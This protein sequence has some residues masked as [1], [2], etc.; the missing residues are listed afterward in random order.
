MTGF[1]TFV[2]VDYSARSVPSPAKPSPDSIWIAVARGAKIDVT[3]HRT[4]SAAQCAL[5]D[6]FESEIRKDRRVLTGFDFPF[7]YPKGFAQAMTGSHDPFALWKVLSERIEDHDDNANNRFD[8][9]EEINQ[10]F[11]APGPFWGCPSGRSTSDLEGTKPRSPAF[12]DRREI[13]EH[14]LRAQTCWKLF[15]TGSVGSQALLGIPRLYALREHFGSDLAVAPFETSDAA[16]VLT[17]IYPSLLAEEVEAQ[18]L[19][20]EILDATQV[21]VVATALSNLAPDRLNAMLAEG[22]K[23]EGWIFG[24]GHVGELIRAAQSKPPLAPPRLQDNCFALPPGVDWTPVPEALARLKA[25]LRPVTVPE[26]LNISQ[27]AG[28]VIALDVHAKRSNPPTANSAVDGFG[29][30]HSS[31]T[32]GPQTLP[33]VEGRSAAG[34]P[35]AG[36]VPAGHAIRIL[37][38]AAIPVGVDTVVLEEDCAVAPD[39]LAFHG[40]VKPGANTRKAGEDV[41]ADDV[42]FPVG[43]RLRAPDLALLAATGI[44]E[45]DVFRPLR[46]AVLSTGDELLEAGAK[47]AA[48]QIYDANRPMLAAMLAGWGYDVVDLGRQPDDPEIIRSVLDRAA[49]DVD[50][51]L[52]SGGASAGDEDHISRLL[53]D[54]GSLS[55]WRIA[56]KPGRPL[57]LA[58]WH[59]VPVFG[60]PGNPVAAL[61]CA[62]LFARP[63][64]SLLAGAGWKEPLR[65]T[66]PAGFT[67]SKKHGRAEYPRAR[68]TDDGKV[69]L[70]KSEGSGRISG[71]TWAEGLVELPFEARDITEGD[72][73]TFLPYQGFGV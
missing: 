14:V 70:F 43:H 40:A 2:A 68:L 12:A 10:R 20:D 44:G 6:L 33:L 35:F 47:A 52:T 16:I 29:F 18:R 36:R 59:G 5:I 49:Q 22:N 1:D 8:V 30:A 45:V 19:P 73:V 63:A 31:I 9:A 34:Q 11:D 60:L 64:L 7:G 71:L 65:M 67:K 4:R 51:I 27:A 69:E 28:R 3:Y 54:H 62:L 53:R 41:A 58:Q 55:S 37:T 50:A 24:F 46:V 23:N 38:G 39:A 66:V 32:S 13:E 25:A 21:R 61:T 26:G 17:E 42:I 15:T 56:L 57:A 72:P 48:G